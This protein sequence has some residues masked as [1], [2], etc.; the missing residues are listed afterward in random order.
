MEFRCPH[1]RMRRFDLTKLGYAALIA[2][3][4]S[5]MIICRFWDPVWFTQNLPGDHHFDWN[6]KPLSPSPLNEL[7]KTMQIYIMT[8]NEWPLIKSNI[9]YHGTIFGF[10][11]IYVIDASTDPLVLAFLRVAHEKLGVN[12]IYSTS[13]LNTVTEEM[14]MIMTIEK[15]STDFLIKLDTDEIVVHYDPTTN[16][17]STNPAIIRSYLNIVPFDGGKLKIGFQAQAMTFSNCSLNDNTFIVSR[18]NA[19]FTP[20]AFKSFF[21]SKTFGSYDLGG[22]EGALLASA[23]ITTS[24]STNLSVM[25]YHYHCFER[26]IKADEQAVISHNY[27]L[28][29]ETLQQ[30][31]EKMTSLAGDFPVTCRVNSCHKV[32]NYLQYLI[33]PEK[34]KDDYYAKFNQSISEENTEISDKMV[35]LETKYKWVT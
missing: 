1:T 24:H 28:G 27:I 19:L 34:A 31:I 8:K 5:I 13:N 14:N 3:C 18:R 35:E 15:N 7:D 30:K 32:F 16:K 11:N 26:A 21:A 2:S 6:M 9:L 29:N 10:E 12:V 20:T 23:N 4:L 33:N 25:H 22:H 17:I